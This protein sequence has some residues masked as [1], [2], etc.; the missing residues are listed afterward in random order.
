MK[1]F[2]NVVILFLLLILSSCEVFDSAFISTDDEFEPNN[3]IEEAID[4][5]AKINILLTDLVAFDED[6]F[7]ITSNGSELIT[8]DVLFTHDESDLD[9]DF[10]DVNGVK[11]TSSNS[12]TDN[13]KIE[14]SVSTAGDYY[15]RIYIDSGIYRASNY[16]LE[17]SASPP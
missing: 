4:I 2:K 10:N 14:Y 5:T 1:A 16:Q 3:K 11:L 15:I 12:A 13:E 7:K 8:I 17:W 6:W 9:V